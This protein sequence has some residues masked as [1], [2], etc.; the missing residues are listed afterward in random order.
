MDFL[1]ENIDWLVDKINQFKD[2]YVIFDMPGN[3]I[4]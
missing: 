3:F 1:Y 2:H 4:F